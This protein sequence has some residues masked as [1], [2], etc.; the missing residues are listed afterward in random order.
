MYRLSTG[1]IAIYGLIRIEGA[2]LNVAEE[3]R[4]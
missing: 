2:E 3:M 1:V 4:A